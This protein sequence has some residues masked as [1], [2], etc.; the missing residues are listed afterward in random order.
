VPKGAQDEDEVRTAREK[1]AV[2]QEMQTG[3]HRDKERPRSQRCFVSDFDLNSEV[4]KRTRMSRLQRRR[5]RRAST[6]DFD[7]KVRR[8]TRRSR[9]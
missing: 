5:R 6:G 1:Q 3:Q 8:T 9:P 4:R 7:S 2:A